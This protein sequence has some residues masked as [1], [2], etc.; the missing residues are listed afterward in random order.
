[1]VQ[2]RDLLSQSDLETRLASINNIDESVKY[3]TETIHEAASQSIPNNVVIIKQSD[4]PC[5][6]CQI[7]N[8]IRKRKRYHKKIKRTSNLQ[9]WAKYKTFRN[10]VVDELRISKKLL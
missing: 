5:V 6:T 7:K 2:F 4:H 8:L 10:K 1:M 9:Y 3:I